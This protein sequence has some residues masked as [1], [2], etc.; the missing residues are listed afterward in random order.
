MHPDN[1]RG[2]FI[3]PTA[4]SS[5]F[6]R[7]FHDIP[8]NVLN[9]IIGFHDTPPILLIGIIHPTFRSLIGSFDEN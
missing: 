1:R 2:R 3:V 6:V 5:A 7:G 8:L 9:I 4:D